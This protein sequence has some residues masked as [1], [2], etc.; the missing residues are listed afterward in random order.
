MKEKVI[1]FSC[2]PLTLDVAFY[3]YDPECTEF[4][5]SNGMP[6][7]A[8]IPEPVFDL[9]CKDRCQPGHEARITNDLFT[10]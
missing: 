2:N 5:D 6:A 8:E 4:V 1:T 9:P 7:K 3:W 10:C